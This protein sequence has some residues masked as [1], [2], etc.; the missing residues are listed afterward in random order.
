MH[1]GPDPGLLRQPVDRLEPAEMV[2]VVALQHRLGKAVQR[3]TIARQIVQDLLLVDRMGRVEPDD[4]LDAIAPDRGT[5]SG[6]GTTPV[7][8]VIRP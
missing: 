3:H 6:G 7:C 5:H 4:P 2:L 8:V 1:A